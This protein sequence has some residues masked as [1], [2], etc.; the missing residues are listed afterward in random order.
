MITIRF[1]AGAAEAAGTNEIQID[2]SSQFSNEGAA[3]KTATEGVASIT[4]TQ[5]TTATTATKAF[6]DTA[7]EGVADTTSDGVAGDVPALDSPESIPTVGGLLDQVAQGNEKLQKV[8][9]VC[10][11]LADGE[12]VERTRPATGISQLDVLPPFAGG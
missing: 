1:F 9:S 5:G 3:G 4:T 11:L 10:L 7:P 12:R 8:L 2:V 6:A